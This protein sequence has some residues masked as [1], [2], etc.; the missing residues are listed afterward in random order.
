MVLDI[1]HCA[2]GLTGGKVA[3]T[4]IQISSRLLVVWA[5]VPYVPGPSFFH[6]ALYSAWSLA[7]SIRF[8]YYL[9]PSKPLT[10]MRFSAFL[11]LYPLGVFGGELPLLWQRARLGDFAATVCG[12]CM[13]AYIP[14]FPILFGHMLTQRRK[15]LGCPQA[16][17]C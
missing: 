9:K 3:T 17:E 1:L 10:W 12:T 6:L 4:L 13:L 8:A 2:L 7:E 15:H 14:G 16:K 11:V 5:V